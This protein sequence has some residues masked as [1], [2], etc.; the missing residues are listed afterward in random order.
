MWYKF[1]MMVSKSASKVAGHNP[2]EGRPVN[3]PD[4]SWNEPV[5]KMS[6]ESSIEDSLGGFERKI[7]FSLVLAEGG[8]I[9]QR[10]RYDI[11]RDRWLRKLVVIPEDRDI[12]KEV[13]DFVMMEVHNQ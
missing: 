10:S 1:W 7:D 9:L 11:T 6:K 5:G 8:V 4:V 2:N 13:G 12:C 3:A